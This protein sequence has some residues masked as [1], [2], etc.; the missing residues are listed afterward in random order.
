V[1]AEREA[2]REL[3][4]Y[5]RCAG[6]DPPASAVLGDVVDASLNLRRASHASVGQLAPAQLHPMSELRCLYHLSLEADDRTGVLRGI[7]EVF[8]RYGVSIRSMEQDDLG[9]SGARLV[10]VT[11]TAAESSMQEILADLR[12]L[13]AVRRVGSLLRVVDGAPVSSGTQR[14]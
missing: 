2:V 13:P 5:G 12:E 4:L 1:F 7:A 11:H 8:E 9:P 3:M 14:Q 6:G 10:F